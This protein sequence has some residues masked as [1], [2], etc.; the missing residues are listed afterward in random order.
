MALTRQELI[1]AAKEVASKAEG[2]V[3]RADFQ[4]ITRISQYHIYRLF[5]DG[6]WSTLRALAGLERHPKDNRVLTD[7][8]LIKEF[9]RVATKLKKVPTWAQFAFHAHMSSDVVRRRFGGLQGALRRYRTWLEV[10]DPEGQ[11]LSQLKVQS[12]HEVPI[13]PRE[14][15]L[16]SH[17]TQPLSWDKAGGTS[18]GPPMDF[19]GFRHQ[20]S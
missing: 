6:G 4:R 16:E 19:R 14:D 8:D 18:Y 2:P 3:S 5:P 12:R 1:E 15:T 9:H 11:L 7:E 13:P 17:R 10:H 20:T